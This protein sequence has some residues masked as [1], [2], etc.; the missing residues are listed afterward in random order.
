M[1]HWY[2]QILLFDHLSFVAV[3]S[4]PLALPLVFPNPFV[5]PLVFPKPFSLRIYYYDLFLHNLIPLNLSYILKDLI[6]YHMTPLLPKPP[7]RQ[8]PPL[9]SLPPPSR[10]YLLYI[11]PVFKIA[12]GSM[13]WACF[14]HL[15]DQ[16]ITRIAYGGHVCERIGTKWAIY[17]RPSID[18]SYQVSVHLASRCQRRRFFLIDQ[19][20]TRISYIGHVC[21][22]IGTKW[23]I[24]IEDFQ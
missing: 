17:R 18:A 22:W 2:Y 23:E 1:C 5:P 10:P 24:F 7:T 16:P 9:S 14:A 3:F 11:R 20:K 6:R 8:C 19:S 4:N 13:G 21:E 15:S 12:R